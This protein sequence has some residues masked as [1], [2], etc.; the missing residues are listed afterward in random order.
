VNARGQTGRQEAGRQA[1]RQG[2]HFCTST[3]MEST[4]AAEAAAA[5]KVQDLFLTRLSE[6]F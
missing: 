1:G 3:K 6:V 4:A 2:C 5:I